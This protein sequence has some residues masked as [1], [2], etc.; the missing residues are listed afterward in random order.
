M[1]PKSFIIHRLVKSEDLNHHGSLFAG[2]GAE[3]MVEAGFIAAAS[4]LN[5]KNIVCLK[6]H[7]IEFRNPIRPG[8]TLCFDA[9]VINT[10]RTSLTSYVSVS[11]VNE[12]KTVVE[13][14]MTFVYVDENTLPKPHGIVIEPV[15]DEDKA[16]Q[17][18]VKE[19]PR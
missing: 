11:I 18:R 7:G 10:G 9:R 8:Q 15:S 16:L 2:R 13:G 17:K 6:I 14:F 12:E 1:E 5:P 19:L 3:W 4:L